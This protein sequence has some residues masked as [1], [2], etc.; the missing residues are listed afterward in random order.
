MS[1]QVAGRRRGRKSN[2]PP[3]ASA[4]HGSH[5]A[6]P[7]TSVD[8][9]QEESSD[10]V[11]AAAQRAE[12]RVRTRI[13][14]LEATAFFAATCDQVRASWGRACDASAAWAAER[15]AA[16]RMLCLGIGSIVAS[17]AS[18]Y[19]LALAGALAGALGIGRLAW[20]DPQMRR[21]DVVAG[22]ALG[23]VAVA[24]GDVLAGGLGDEAYSGPLLL[25]MP[26]CD[27]ALYERALLAGAGG[28][29]S[30]GMAPDVAAAR[31]G[32]IV[33]IGNSFR[34]YT[35]RDD[36]RV[37]PAGTPGAPGA[38]NMIRDLQSFT[39]EQALPEHPDCPEAF[40]DLAILSFSAEPLSCG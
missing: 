4:A 8:D 21:A 16:P 2:A 3:G 7:L 24:S 13:S 25:Y 12:A 31:L 5:D 18:A 32:A 11:A 28:D 22:D 30:A 10:A 23:F 29:P 9:G 26:H 15:T 20:A 17:N 38:T 27:R 36:L 37:V 39:H 34:L 14:E 35:D 33:L 6:G 1:W 19:Q 40:N